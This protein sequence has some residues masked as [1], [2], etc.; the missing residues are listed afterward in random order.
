MSVEQFLS[1]TPSPVLSAIIWAVIIIAILYLARSTV[2][3]ALRS[4]GGIMHNAL[5]LGS[6]SISRAEAR[7]VD[8]NR[9]VLLATG[10]EAKE[11]VIEREFERVGDSVDKD[12]SKY[13]A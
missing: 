9:E 5:R 3:A 6:R 1:L 2:H 4:A 12:L 10:R 8:R 7:L 11:R 13:P